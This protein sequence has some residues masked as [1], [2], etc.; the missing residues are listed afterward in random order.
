VL[1]GAADYIGVT[2]HEDSNEE[3]CPRSC[4]DY[5]ACRRQVRWRWV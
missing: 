4:Y 2:I 5:P 3:I 1:A